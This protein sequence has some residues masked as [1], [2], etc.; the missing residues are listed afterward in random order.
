[1]KFYNVRFQLSTANASKI[2]TATTQF[3][4]PKNGKTLTLNS[5]YQLDSNLGPLSVQGP[6]SVGPKVDGY[7]MGM[8][9][10]LMSELGIHEGEVIY[11]KMS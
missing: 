8:S 1:M 9:P 3:K 11:F 5:S 10:A 4:N 2:R 6:I 7:G